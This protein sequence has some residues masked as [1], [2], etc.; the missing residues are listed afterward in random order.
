[1]RTHTHTRS[2]THTHS[3]TDSR[4]CKA[5]GPICQCA[6]VCVSV[7]CV[8][9]S[10]RTMRC[11][12]CCRVSRHCVVCEYAAT[13]FSQTTPPPPSP[14]PQPPSLSKP[15][16]ILTFS[17]FI[18]ANRRSTLFLRPKNPSAS[19]TP[20]AWRICVRH[21]RAQHFTYLIY[22]STKN[23]IFVLRIIYILHGYHT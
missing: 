18:Q 12:Y 10:F 8:R 17:L 5:P 23:T 11:A 19:Q 2:R 14:R 15:T 20:D 9:Y 3:Q 13:T 4:L 21:K 6:Y 16:T 7:C 1:M 22:L